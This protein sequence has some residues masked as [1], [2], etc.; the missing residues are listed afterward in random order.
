MEPDPKLDKHFKHS[1]E[2]LELFFY[3]KNVMPCC[4]KEAKF[5][6]G[7]EGGLCQNIK[8]FHCGHR[9]NI[10]EHSRYIEDIEKEIPAP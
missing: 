5:F 8:C 2:S 4:M 1:K 6:R 9:W 7:P 3:E 10:D